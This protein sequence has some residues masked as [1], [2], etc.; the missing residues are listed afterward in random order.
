MTISRLARRADE[1]TLRQAAESRHVFIVLGKQGGEQL[2]W[3]NQSDESPL[4][5]D[6]RDR[7]F[8][9]M[10]GRPGHCLQI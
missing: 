8:S 3:R 6:D 7:A 5:V 9:M 4:V 2:V 1:A 10:H